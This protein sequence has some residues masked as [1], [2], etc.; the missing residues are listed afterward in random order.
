MFGRV[1]DAMADAAE[2]LRQAFAGLKV[3]QVEAEP[4]RLGTRGSAALLAVGAALGH[5]RFAF[6][7]QLLP[8]RLLFRSEDRLDL[9]VN[10]LAG[11]GEFCLALFAAERLIGPQG[12]H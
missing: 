1:K 8:F 10:R 4:F 3:V 7:F 12:L 9:C 11:F 6:L 5:F 2:T